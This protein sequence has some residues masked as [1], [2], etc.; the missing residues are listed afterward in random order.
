MSRFQFV[1]DHRDT[2][3]VKRLC[4]VIEVNRS[5][6][7]AWDAAA[8]VR[9][10]RQAAHAQLAQRIRAVHEIDKAYGAPRVTAELN[11]DTPPEKRVNRKRVARV[12]AE[13]GIAGIRLRRRVRTTIPEPSEEKVPD[14]LKREFTAETPNTKYVGD[15]QTWAASH[16]LASTALKNSDTPTRSHAVARSLDGRP[17]TTPAGATP[18]AAT[19]PRTPTRTS[20]RL[21][22]RKP[23]NETHPVSKI[24]GQGPS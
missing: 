2:F 14:L 3:E 15:I 18:I 1:A 4:E 13:H 12:M 6:F 20:S 8:P 17:A 24:R 9:A 7:Y 11:D 5:S 23:R 21:P 16:P 19:K 22:F 10:E